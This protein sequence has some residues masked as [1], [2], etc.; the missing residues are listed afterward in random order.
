MG[1]AMASVGVLLFELSPAEE[2]GANSAS[3]Q[4]SDA[5]FSITFIGLAGVIFG[6]AHEPGGQT[7][8]GVFAVILAL[9][10]VLALFGAC[11]A[12]RVRVARAE[13]VPDVR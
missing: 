7:S 4:L 6:S 11:A 8:S 5:L 10:A 12:G 9:M 2:H 3:L 1:M 13:A